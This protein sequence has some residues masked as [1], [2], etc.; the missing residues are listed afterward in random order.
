V[1]STV[2]IYP[3]PAT[4]VISFTSSLNA[5]AVEVFDI[6]GRKVGAFE[7]RGNAVTIELSSFSTG[8]YIYNVVNEKKEVIN[9]GK[10]EVTK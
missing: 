6:A 5:A 9:R 8:M 4:N 1:P 3:N 10:F 7:M 2:S